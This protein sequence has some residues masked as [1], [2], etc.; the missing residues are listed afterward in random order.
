MATARQCCS[1]R[2][3]SP[4][5]VHSKPSPALRQCSFTFSLSSVR[6][7]VC[8]GTSTPGEKLRMYFRPLCSN[9]SRTV[10]SRARY[11]SRQSTTGEFFSYL[12]TT[13]EKKLIL[14]GQLVKCELSWW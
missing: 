9:M 2:K 8:Q 12:A 4:P 13:T 11:T 14:R 10:G 3:H 7:K 5:W 6:K 1:R